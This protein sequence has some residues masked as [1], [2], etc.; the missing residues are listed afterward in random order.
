MLFEW[1]LADNWFGAKENLEYINSIIKK[2]FIIGIKSNRTV[3]FSEKE[4]L[5]G[6]FTKVSKL[7]LEYGGKSTNFDNMLAAATLISAAAYIR[8][9]S[10][11][12]H[13]RKDF[14]NKNEQ[15]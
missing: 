15:Y 13:Y 1:V 3:A 2:K 6:D 8:E 12:G 7:D 11:G 14:P 10:R 5:K 4:K 9:E